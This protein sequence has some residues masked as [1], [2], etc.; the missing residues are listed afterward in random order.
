MVPKVQHVSMYQSC[1]ARQQNIV[2]EELNTR[3]SID[4]RRR[5]SYRFSPTRPKPKPTPHARRNSPRAPSNEHD[6]RYVS[7]YKA[8]D[9]PQSVGTDNSPFVSF[10]NKFL[11]MNVKKPKE[12]KVL[13]KRIHYIIYTDGAGRAWLQKL[14]P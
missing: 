7:A 1:Y 5:H 12:K 6:T 4:Q 14:Q 10:D 8:G 11:L 13:S 2:Q 9:F 3:D